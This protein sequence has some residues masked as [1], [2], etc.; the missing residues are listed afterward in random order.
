MAT[1]EAVEQRLLLVE[2][3]MQQLQGQ[4]RTL[5]EQQTIQMQSHSTLHDEL[6]GV[7]ARARGGGLASIDKVLMPSKYGGDK[8]QWRQFAK[9][10]INCV[11]K[12]YP[13]ITPVMKRTMGQS[14]IIDSTKL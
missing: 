3:L 7:A 6:R 10:L 13:D 14:E 2:T 11:G 5:A 9:K 1:T 8:T 4:V 12:T